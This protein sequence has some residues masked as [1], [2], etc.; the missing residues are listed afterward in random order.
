[1]LSELAIDNPKAFTELV[2]VSKNALEGKVAKTETQEVKETKT[3]E[4]KKEPVS[5]DEDDID[6]LLNDLD[7]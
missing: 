4:P 2:T 3:K 5:V 7:I 1:M 6:D